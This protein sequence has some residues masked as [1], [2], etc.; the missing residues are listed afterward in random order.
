M[1]DLVLG[2]C[3]DNMSK[4]GSEVV[5]L[6]VTSPPY[7]DL[8]TY[9]GNNEAWGE[10]VW[11][12][13]IEE[14]F[15]VTKKGGVVV[16]VVNDATINGSETGTSFRQALW[17]M[18]CGFNLHDTM[19]YQKNGLSFP[20]IVR[21]YSCF[22]Y[23]FVF[24]KG[25]P[26][27]INLLQDRKN[28]KYGSLVSGTERDKYGKLK[29][30]SAKK[31]NTGRRIKKHGVRFNIWKY[32]IGKGHLAETDIAHQHPAIFPLKLAKDH[33]LSWS[34]KGDLVFD[35]FMGSGTTGVA[36]LIN[37]RKFLGIELEK[38]YLDIAR[39]R[40]GTMVRF[41]IPA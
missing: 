20:D 3:V 16:W 35:P 2:C 40:L 12:A 6:T 32:N 24:S 5:D 34:N 23:M 4:M 38:K 1:Y 13:C 18:E 31:N 41:G 26:K 29:I 36:A 21:Y 14:L 25:K 37:G 10:D 19:V 15:R 33:I 22:E 17:A 8:R 9:E 27:T 7:D 28:E 30:C 39:K 11:K